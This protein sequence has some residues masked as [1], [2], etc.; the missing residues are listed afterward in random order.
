VR[1]TD[2]VPG[3]EATEKRALTVL[4]KSAEVTDTGLRTTVDRTL[5]GVMDATNIIT[6]VEPTNNRTLE[7]L[8]TTGVDVYGC[9][10]EV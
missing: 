9:C 5:A 2:T 10:A 3:Q 4:H 1:V 6:G 7:V 8:H